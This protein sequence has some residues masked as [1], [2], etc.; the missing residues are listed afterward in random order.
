MEVAMADRMANL[1]LRIREAI[2]LVLIVGIGIL[3][4]RTSAIA[5]ER[6]NLGAQV[7][8]ERQARAATELSLNAL[9]YQ[10]ASGKLN[11]EVHQNIIDSKIAEAQKRAA[12][13]ERQTE[14]L[15]SEKV[16]EANCVTPKSI[17]SGDL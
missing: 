9:K 7:I 5:A 4:W 17:R 8:A 12:E 2:I 6:D 11:S 3:A 10:V 13:L 16:R 15:R 1:G 14:S